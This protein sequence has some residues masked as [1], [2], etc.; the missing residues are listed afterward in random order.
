LALH[1]R[2]DEAVLRRERLL[3]AIRQFRAIRELAG[4]PLLLT[5]LAIIGKH[6]ELPRERWKIYDHAASVLVE[7]WDVNRHLR[8]Q[9]I[10]QDF[11]GEE[12]KKELLRRIAYRMQAGTGGLAGNYLTGEDLR[13]ELEGY[14]VLRYQQDPAQ[15]KIIA[16]AMLS[17][18]R[19]RSF[20]LSRYGPGVY[21]FVHRAFLEYFC[22]WALVR[23]FE[24]SQELSADQLKHDVFGRHW[25][26]PSWWEVLRLIVGMIDER[27]AGELIAFL[28]SDAY[29][30]WPLDLE[31]RPPSNVALAVQCLGEL[32][33]LGEV[34]EQAEL[35]LRVVISLLEHSF[36]TV[37][38]ALSGML[39]SQLLPAVE[40]IGSAWPGR[41][42]Y[43]NWYRNRGSR[44]SYS[45]TR[46]V[47]AE[48]AATLFPQSHELRDLFVTKIGSDV[49][50][51]DEE[52]TQG[53]ARLASVNSDTLAWLR[54]RA[55]NGR[56]PRVRRAAVNAIG[57]AAP[58]D[59]DTLKLLRDRATND[60]NAGVRQTVVIAIGQAARGDP[61]TLAWLRRLATKDKNHDIRQ[62]AVIAI[63][64]AA[65]S[66]PDSLKLLR[67]LATNDENPNVRQA[68]VIA[69][70]RAAPSDPDTLAWLRNLAT[71]DENPDVRQAAART[72]IGAKPADP[73]IL[74]WLPTVG[75]GQSN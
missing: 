6:Q 8:D 59:P 12:D 40:I 4:N 33:N 56:N 29:Q 31:D 52:A 18:F 70:G 17:Q 68:A 36:G 3:A 32:R 37:S 60:K 71:N 72:V 24:K 13:E 30:P 21:G 51:G 63:N 53:L 58:G 39:R 5:I 22:A 66:D 49:I 61:D 16:T 2:P 34:R 26:D 9:R 65:P 73:H 46:I 35:V 48:I 20:I 47:T 44:S 69:I 27:H 11:L 74:A 57:R 15:A 62:A 43:L 25:S 10:Q 50:F 28:A 45:L 41:D 7:H 75:P 19:E 64:Q 54:N 1:D 42:N 38:V 14:L 67:N 23:Q 55:T